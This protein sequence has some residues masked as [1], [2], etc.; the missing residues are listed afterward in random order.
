MTIKG[1]DSVP[2]ER[3]LFV[4]ARPPGGG[5]PYAVVRRPGP[6]F[7]AQVRLDDLVSMNP[8]APLSSAPAVEVIVRAS[9]TGT[10]RRSP[11]DWQWSSKTLSFADGQRQHSLVAELS[12]P[13]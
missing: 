12:P 13:G 5:M 10:A 1:L 11:D 6:D 7:P 3:T 4:I 2:A 9:V 8:A